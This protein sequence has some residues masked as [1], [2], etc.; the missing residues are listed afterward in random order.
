MGARSA[1]VQNKDLQ[2]GGAEYVYCS[3]SGRRSG[4]SQPYY[5]VML[6]KIAKPVQFELQQ[7]ITDYV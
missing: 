5:I 7:S 1:F 4:K 3:K 6:E 2:D